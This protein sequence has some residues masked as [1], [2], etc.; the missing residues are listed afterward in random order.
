MSHFANKI[1][2]KSL[3]F[4]YS[5]D[6]CIIITV[7]IIYLSTKCMNHDTPINGAN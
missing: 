5:L 1:F 4:N 2:R 3:N 7:I 6:F